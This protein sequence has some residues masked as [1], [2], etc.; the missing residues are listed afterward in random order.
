MSSHTAPTAHPTEETVA[1]D[2][3]AGNAWLVAGAVFSLLL[4]YVVGID[5]GAVT[6]FGKIAPVHEFLH[7]ARHFLGYP[8]H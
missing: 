2:V 8:C 1:L 7:D 3:S 6:V 5:Q 4:F